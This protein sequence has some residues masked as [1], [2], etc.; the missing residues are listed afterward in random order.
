MGVGDDITTSEAF[1]VT[2]A[3]L[4]SSLALSPKEAELASGQSQT[5]E[6][7]SIDVEGNATRL[8]SS[9]VTFTLDDNGTGSTLAPDTGTVTAGSSAGDATLTATMNKVTPEDTVDGKTPTQSANIAVVAKTLES[10]D[11]QLPENLTLIP[12]QEVPLSALGYYN[13]DTTA[14][15]SNDVVVK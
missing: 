6:A 15:L 9:W 2:P 12:G 8:D 4:I 14:V 5:F 7:Y 11:V 3:K 1:D 13:D 10:L